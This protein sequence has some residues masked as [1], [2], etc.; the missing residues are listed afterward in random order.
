[1]ENISIIF[2]AAGLSQRFGKNK[3]IEIIDNK[4]L[5]QYSLDIV[6]K[7]KFSEIIIITNTKEI[8]E[9]AT[10]NNIS[11]FSN[12]NA[13]LGQ[14][15]T[16][17]LGIKEAKKENNY[18]FLTA[19][20]PNLKENIITSIVNHFNQH[21]NITMPRVNG[22]TYNPVIYPNIYREKL[23]NIKDA[24]TG[25]SIITPDDIISYMDFYNSSFFKD[26]DYIN[27]IF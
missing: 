11:V 25:K 10:K 3:L 16:I 6:T 18:M 7:M 19:D 20:M 21:N 24:S 8:I 14:G 17:K 27:D 1:M 15:T 5:F 23:Y 26:I 22:R 13:H 12:E 4:F 2:M 9:Y